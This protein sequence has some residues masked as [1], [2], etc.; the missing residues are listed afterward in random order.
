M[1]LRFG[2]VAAVGGLDGRSLRRARPV[3][4]VARTDDFA[5]GQPVR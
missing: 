1:L 5:T 4:V 2:G 3:S